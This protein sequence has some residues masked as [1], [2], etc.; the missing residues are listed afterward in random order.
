M[1]QSGSLTTH[2]RAASLIMVMMAWVLVPIINRV[3]LRCARDSLGRSLSL[4]FIRYTA[5]QLDRGWGRS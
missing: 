2:Q 4:R 1:V 5:E 3:L